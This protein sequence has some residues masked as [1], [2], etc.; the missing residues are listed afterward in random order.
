MIRFLIRVLIQALLL[1]GCMYA[2]YLLTVGVIF[3]EALLVGGAFIGAAMLIRVA[4]RL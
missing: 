1:V 4:S 3:S 2:G